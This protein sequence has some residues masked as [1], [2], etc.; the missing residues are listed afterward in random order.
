MAFRKKAKYLLEY[1]ADIYVIQESENTSKLDVTDLISYPNRIWVGANNNKGLLVVAKENIKIETY[2][3]YNPS[4]RFILPVRIVS[5]KYK[6]N[7]VAVWAQRDKENNRNRYIGQVWLALQEYKSMRQE[8]IIIVGDFNS[9]TL[10]D[11][12]YSTAV[13]HSQM[14]AF[15]E[16]K[17]ITSLYHW[18]RQEKQGEETT[19]TLAFRKDVTNGYHIDYCFLSQS[20][21]NKNTNI[22]ILGFEDWIAKSDH[23]PL[24][25]DL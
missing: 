17:C 1:D 18:L 6:F 8:D 12:D 2:N 24:I 7:L 23:V 19:N 20:M 14:V 16:N 25:I 5:D 22:D 3:D 15:L 4:F 11:K 10:W 9:N 21:I 13:S